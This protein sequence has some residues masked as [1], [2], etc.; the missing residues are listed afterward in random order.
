M[1]RRRRVVLVGFDMHGTHFFGTHPSPLRNTGNFSGFI[2]RFERAAKSLPYGVE[3]INATPGSALT[4][5][6]RLSLVEALAR[7]A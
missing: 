4:C 5:F 1:T 7:I 6:E 3:I 2:Q